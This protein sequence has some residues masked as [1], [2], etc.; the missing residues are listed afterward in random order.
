MKVEIQTTLNLKDDQNWKVKLHSFYNLIQALYTETYS[1]KDLLGN[2][3]HIENI[4]A[5]LDKI[6]AAFSDPQ[7]TKDT[8]EE[9]SMFR[10]YIT[11]EIDMTISEGSSLGLSKLSEIEKSLL[12]FEKMLAVAQDRTDE[13]LTFIDYKGKRLSFSIESLRFKMKEVFATM[14]SR[15]GGRY[16]V[17]FNAESKGEKDYFFDLQFPSTTEIM[18]PVLFPDVIRDL[19][20]NSKK[21][22]PIGS[23]ISCKLTTDP[24]VTTL[25]VHD[26]G[27]GIP[28]SNIDQVVNFG[29]RGENVTEDETFGDGFGLTKA[30]MITKEHGGRM[31]ID[32][33]EGEY[34]TITIELPTNI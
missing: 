20:A 4:I 15:S 29:Y 27:R 13:F 34:T 11:D 5:V 2:N 23:T 1:L 18:L 7:Q 14:A 22:S 12:H 17:A 28:Q 32:S 25:I 26:E 3:K 21:Y 31:F 19:L 16:G 10:Q 24:E 9:L 6:Q 30:Y 33:V 8:L